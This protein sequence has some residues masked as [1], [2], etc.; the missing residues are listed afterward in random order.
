MIGA[1]DVVRSR[2]LAVCL[3]PKLGRNGTIRQAAQI[4]AIRI[5]KFNVP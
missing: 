1:L 5:P 3:I 2:G 4:A